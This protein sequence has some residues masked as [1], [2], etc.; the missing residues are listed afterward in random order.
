MYFPEFP[1]KLHDRADTIPPEC[2]V[3]KTPAVSGVRQ[4]HLPWY[5][6]SLLYSAYSPAHIPAATREF[7]QILKLFTISSIVRRF[8]FAVK[9]F[10]V[11]DGE[12]ISDIVKHPAASDPPVFRICILRIARRVISICF[13][14]AVMKSGN[15]TSAIYHTRLDLIQTDLLTAR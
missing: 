12:M 15:Y 7:P 14:G 4:A 9:A 5:F 11:R 8:M 6:S 2:T 1:I 13:P 10:P 3:Q